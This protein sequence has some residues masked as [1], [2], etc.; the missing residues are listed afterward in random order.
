MPST[1]RRFSRWIGPLPQ[2]TPAIT[3]W[4]IFAIISAALLFVLIAHPIGTVVAIGALTVLTLTTERKRA[5]RVFT[6]A[7]ARTAEDI[8]SFARG[9]NR[10]DGT[11]LDPWAIRAVWNAL[12]PLT[13]SRGRRIPLRPTD[14]FEQDL[15]IDLE[16]LEDLVPPL[17]EQ[18]ERV[19]GDWKT[20]PFYDKLETVAD[21]VHFISAQRRRQSA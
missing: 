1:H 14:R 9:F 20:N 7:S 19:H 17:V 4:A 10:R 18:C 3:D 15:G 13:E 12:A 21:L 8:G 11:P 16:D 2:R 5:K 6:A